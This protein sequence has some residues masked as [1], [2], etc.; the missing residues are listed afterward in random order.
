[1]VLSLSVQTSSSQLCMTLSLYCLS[2]V[3][4]QPA[5]AGHQPKGLSWPVQALPGLPGHPGPAGRPERPTSSKI[6][7]TGAPPLH[8]RRACL[9]IPSALQAQGTGLPPPARHRACLL[10][11]ARPIGRPAEVSVILLVHCCMC[12]G[13]YGL[14]HDGAPRHGQR[15]QPRLARAWRAAMAK[16]CWRPT[17]CISIVVGWPLVCIAKKGFISSVLKATAHPHTHC[18]LVSLW[19]FLL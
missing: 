2:H 16:G 7:K 19:P 15:R 11:P 17:W 10:P 13:L 1:M 5:P 8:R 14:C 18:T 12:S 4:L 9:S 3:R 6:L